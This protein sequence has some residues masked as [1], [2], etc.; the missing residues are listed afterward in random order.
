MEPNVFETLCQYVA[1][2]GKP[3]TAI[4]LLCEN[5]VGER[6]NHA[7]S[8]EGPGVNVQGLGLSVQGFRVKLQ[9]E[10][11]KVTLAASCAQLGGLVCTI[12]NNTDPGCMHTCQPESNGRERDWLAATGARIMLAG[13]MGLHGKSLCMPL[14]ACHTQ[15]GG[16]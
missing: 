13:A 8:Q 1:A 9:G 4:E 16:F 5:Y 12:S 7:A 11:L 10:G 15:I 6:C 3:R 2:H 14:T